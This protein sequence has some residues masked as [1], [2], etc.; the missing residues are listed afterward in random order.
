MLAGNG[1]FHAAG[2]KKK[3][4]AAWMHG[5]HECGPGPLTWLSWTRWR[6]KKAPLQRPRPYRPALTSVTAAGRDDL[7]GPYGLCDP[8]TSHDG[9]RDA[10]ARA[11]S[12]VT[13]A[14]P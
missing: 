9:P 4:P 3:T 5:D 10:D 14:V 8:T 12:R 7:C 6:K 13:G 2:K 11:P 1:G